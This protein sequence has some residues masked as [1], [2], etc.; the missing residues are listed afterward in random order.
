MIQ[1]PDDVFFQTT[2]TIGTVYY[3]IS[4]EIQSDEPH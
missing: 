1:I 3:Y 4:E 2:L